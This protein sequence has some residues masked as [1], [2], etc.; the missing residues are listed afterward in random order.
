MHPAGLEPATLGSEGHKMVLTGA[1]RTF[2]ISSKNGRFRAIAVFHS[3]TEKSRIL[4]PILI[5]ASQ[6]GDS[7][8]SDTD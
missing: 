5:P 6:S 8:H 1:R 4:I 3:D 7:I 2:G